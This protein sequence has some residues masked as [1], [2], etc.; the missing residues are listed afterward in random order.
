MYIYTIKNLLNGKIYVGQT[1][2][3]NPLSKEHK[4]KVSKSGKLAW[5]KRKQQMSGGT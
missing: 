3:A 4:R 2:Q 5:V 1:I